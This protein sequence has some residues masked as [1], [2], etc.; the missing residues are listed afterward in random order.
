[1]KS[2]GVTISLADFCIVL[3]ETKQAMFFTF[4]TIITGLITSRFMRQCSFPEEDTNQT[5]R[6]S[7]RL[8]GRGSWSALH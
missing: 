8:A 7:K 6:L 3:Y 4:T 1:M 5:L 2:F